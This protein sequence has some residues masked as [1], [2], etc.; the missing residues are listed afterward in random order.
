M[1]DGSILAIIRPECSPCMWE[2]WSRDGGAT[3]GPCVRGPFPGYATPNMVRT[4]SGAVLVAHRLPTMSIHC[5]LDE[6]HTWDQGTMIDN[7]I[8][9]MGAMCEVEPDLVLYCYMDTF[10]RL[11]RAQF[12]RVTPAGLEPATPGLEG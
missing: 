10:E 4:S 9:C 5:S 12:L 2:T 3:L 7:A 6:G 1:S 8:W 11:M